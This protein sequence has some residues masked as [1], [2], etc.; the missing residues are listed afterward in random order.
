GED[1]NS[2]LRDDGDEDRVLDRRPEGRAVDETLKVVEADEPEPRRADGDVA[3]AVDDGQRE[4][5]THQRHDVEERPRPHQPA[6]PPPLRQQADVPP[7]AAQLGRGAV[8]GPARRLS[9]RNPVLRSNH[10]R[11]GSAMTNSQR[12]PGAPGG[13][14]P[15]AVRTIAGPSGKGG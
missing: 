11:S 1:D 15:A 7:A 5:K 3:E 4:R 6:E 8:H 2:E 10:L 9:Q 12:S 13:G 14:S